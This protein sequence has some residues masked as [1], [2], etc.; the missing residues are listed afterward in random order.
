MVGKVDWSYKGMLKKRLEEIF[1]ITRMT[2]YG[3]PGTQK[4]VSESFPP[5]CINDPQN[6]AQQEIEQQKFDEMNVHLKNCS[7]TN[8]KN[9]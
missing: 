8:K 2:V 4:G 9:A 1:P 7:S 3:S 5:K 6:I